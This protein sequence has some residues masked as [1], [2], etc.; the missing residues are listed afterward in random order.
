MRTSSSAQSLLPGQV[1]LIGAGP[2]DPDLLTVRAV[3][4]LQQ[5]DVVLHDFLVSDEILDLVPASAKRIL[6]GKRCSNHTVPQEGINQLLIDQAR[7]GLRVCR[8]KGGDPLI[9]GRGGEELEALA[10]AGIRFQIVPG[11][12]AAAGCGAAA[13]IPL[14][15]RDY[16][17][18]V[19]FV[20]GHRRDGHGLLLDWPTLASADKTLVFYM[21]LKNLPEIGRQLQQHGLPD[22]LPLAVIINGTRDDQQVLTGTL[23]E[24][25]IDRDSIQGPALVIVGRVVDVR[26]T[27]LAGLARV[28]GTGNSTSISEPDRQVI[29]FSD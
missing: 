29:G 16:A 26:A 3:R 11:I 13:G 5:A 22:D 7:Q 15:H 27:L 28:Y 17:Q 20:T 10:A 4:L 19:V 18:E 14:T 25:P 1:A 9:F 23:S 21:G 2:G 8:L 6:V 12:T 24:P